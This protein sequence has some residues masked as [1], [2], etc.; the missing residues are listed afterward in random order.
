MVYGQKSNGR[1]V[2]LTNLENVGSLTSH[3]RI[4]L[5]GLIHGQ[6]YFLHVDDVRTSAEAWTITVRYGDS[7]TFFICR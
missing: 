2:N 7:F 1:R 4:V 5:D 6:C 3:Y